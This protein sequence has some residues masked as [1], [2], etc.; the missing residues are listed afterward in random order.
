MYEKWIDHSSDQS[1][2]VESAPYRRKKERGK[3]C[4]T[5]KPPP[6]DL[7]LS[8][9]GGL[10]R[11]VLPFCKMGQRGARLPYPGGAAAICTG[12]HPARD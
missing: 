5:D 9:T 10:H 8:D 12:V 2:A 1:R 4:G 11:A 6:G 7:Q 3:G